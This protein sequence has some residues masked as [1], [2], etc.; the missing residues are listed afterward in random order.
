MNSK[1]LVWTTLPSVEA[2][3]TAPLATHAAAE[4]DAAEDARASANMVR[5]LACVRVLACVRA[6]I[7][8]DG[9]RVRVCRWVV[10]SGGVRA[11]GCA[12]QPLAVIRGSGLRRRAV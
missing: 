6:G 12:R 11:G 2:L 4:E 7:A 5:K 8:I 3:R 1:L 10:M 9:W